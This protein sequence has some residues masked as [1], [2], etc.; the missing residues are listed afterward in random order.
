MSAVI[1]FECFDG[2]VVQISEC[3]Y[4][5]VSKHRWRFWFEYAGCQSLGM[6]LHQFIIGPKP[7]DIPDDYVVDH[8]D[9]NKS[10]NTLNN[11]RYV[12]RAFNSFNRQY[13]LGSSKFRGVRW[14][15]GT[16]KWAASFS[17]T[18][19]GLF[20]DEKLAAKIVAKAAIIKWSS[21]VIDSVFLFGPGLLSDN[22]KQDILAEINNDATKEI[23]AKRSL[24]T[25]VIFVKEKEDRYPFKPYRVQADKKHIGYFETTLEAQIAYDDYIQGKQKRAWIEHSA[26][27]IEK[28][29]EGEAIIH[30][31]GGSGKGKVTTVPKSLWHQLTFQHS[32]SLADSYAHGR[33]EGRT[34]RLHQVVYKLLNPTWDGKGSIDHIIP[35][36]KLN[37]TESNLR[38][39]LTQSAQEANKQKRK[40]TTSQYIGVH[41]KSDTG[42][43]VAKLQY[44]GRTISIGRAFLTEHDACRARNERAERL[45]LP[46]IQKIN[47][48]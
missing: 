17:G 35:A 21:W 47:E 23:K 25:G 8:V 42:R 15:K 16:N 33:F 12:S 4:E 27:L 36:E 46:I 48:D 40:N 39:V 37:N 11:L 19:L 26:K 41:Q 18:S 13:P 6:Q 43:F 45:G 3:D 2:K 5:R 31:S 38:L 10:N 34:R 29:D 14:N 9:G 30:L 44:Q 28:N 22:D 20:E 24:P 1:D 7:A 32:W